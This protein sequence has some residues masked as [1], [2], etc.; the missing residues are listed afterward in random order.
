MQLGLHRRKSPVHLGFLK[1][2]LQ[3]IEL[4]SKIPIKVNNGW[5]ADYRLAT[6][7][8][9]AAGERGV[10]ACAGHSKLRA[11]HS[12]RTF[13]EE[14]DVQSMPVSRVDERSI[15]NVIQDSREPRSSPCWEFYPQC[16]ARQ[17]PDETEIDFSVLHVWKD[18][19]LRCQSVRTSMVSKRCGRVSKRWEISDMLQNAL[20]RSDTLI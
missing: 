10:K 3:R 14:N 4:F 1:V 17:S 8:L 11:E 20:A 13:D 6:L 5:K 16:S 12:S 18:M 15:D 9:F 2:S 19:R 7:N